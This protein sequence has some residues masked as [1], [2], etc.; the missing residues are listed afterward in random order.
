MKAII[1]DVTIEVILNSL[2]LA[3]MA[4]MIRIMFSRLDS[5][6]DTI[7]IFLGSI[8]FGV[9]AGYVINDFED[10][11]PYIKIIVV[12]FSIFGKELFIWL[13]KV[14]KD[15]SKHIG[16]VVSVIDALKSIKVKISKEEKNN[17]SS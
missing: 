10:I 7:R 17:G 8:L 11:K 9:I 15:P 12:I 1:L 16:L 4:A 2:L 5:F 13:E 6:S 3:F 14:F